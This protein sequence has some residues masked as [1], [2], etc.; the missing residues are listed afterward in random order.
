MT[1]S[2]APE[3]PCTDRRPVLRAFRI[4]LLVLCLVV[5]FAIPGTA[6]AD[7]A[8][9]HWP[10]PPPHPVVNAFDAP[11][12]PYGP[13]HRG[14]DIAVTGTSAP[15]HAVEA[16]TVRFSG[17]V[18]GR[19]VVSVLHADGL[20]ST[21]EPVTGTVEKGQEVKAGDVLGTIA[22]GEASHC[23]D[24]VCLHLGARRGQGYLD[25]MLLLGARG[26]SVLLP[27]GGSSGVGTVGMP[28]AAQPRTSGTSITSITSSTSSTSGTSSTSSTAHDE[29]PEPAMVPITEPAL[30]W[31]RPLPA[32]VGAGPGGRVALAP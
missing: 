28:A 12:G 19:G 4:V 17:A 8:R 16:G 11:D 7:D 24:Q 3:R 27:W 30:S 6:R 31:S 15:V 2:P 9:W 1:P 32:G 29:L 21:Y 10:L 26:P 18:A 20:I 5:A 25:P 22:D 23:S 14:I 13:G